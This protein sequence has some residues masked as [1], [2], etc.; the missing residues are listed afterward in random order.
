[1]D[2]TVKGHLTRTSRAKQ[3]MVEVPLALAYSVRT[4]GAIAVAAGS[5]ILDVQSETCI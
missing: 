2:L 5:L 1:M 4:F 3:C